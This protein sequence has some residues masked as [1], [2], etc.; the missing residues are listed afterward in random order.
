MPDKQGSVSLHNF[1]SG[2]IGCPVSASIA[3]AEAMEERLINGINN[4]NKNIQYEKGSNSLRNE[5]WPGVLTLSASA[6]RSMGGFLS[7]FPLNDLIQTSISLY[8]SGFL[9]QKGA[10]RPSSAIEKQSVLP[11]P[12]VGLPHVICTSE[13]MQCCVPQKSAKGWRK[14]APSFIRVN[15][16]SCEAIYVSKTDMFCATTSLYD[17][18]LSGS[19]GNCGMVIIETSEHLIFQNTL[20][21]PS[22]EMNNAL[23]ECKLNKRDKS[24]HGS[25][26]WEYSVQAVQTALNHK[27]EGEQ[28]STGVAQALAWVE[29]VG[30]DPNPTVNG[31]GELISQVAQRPGSDI[32][33]ITQ[34]PAIS[35]NAVANMLQNQQYQQYQHSYQSNYPNTYNSAHTPS[36][37]NGGLLPISQYGSSLRKLVVSYLPF[38]ISNDSYPILSSI[39]NIKNKQSETLKCL[40]S[41]PEK[42]QVWKSI[43][44]D[45]LTYSYKNPRCIP[46]TIL[47][48][49]CPMREVG[50]KVNDVD[51]GLLSFSFR[52]MRFID[53]AKFRIACQFKLINC[54]LATLSHYCN[55]KNLGFNKKQREENLRSSTMAQDNDKLL[56]STDKFNLVSTNYIPYIPPED[57][58]LTD[59]TNV[60]NKYI[61]VYFPQ[62]GEESNI[63]LVQYYNNQTK[64]NFAA[65]VINIEDIPQSTNVE[66]IF[67]DEDT[68]FQYLGKVEIVPNFN[69]NNE[70]NKTEGLSESTKNINEENYT[71]EEDFKK[72]LQNENY[73]DNDDD[74]PLLLDKY[75]PDIMG[76]YPE[77]EMKQV[78]IE[79]PYN[80]NVG[81][82]DDFYTFTS[83]L[84]KKR[85]S[86]TKNPNKE[87][88][89]SSQ[90]NYSSKYGRFGIFL[91][92][93]TIL[94]LFIVAG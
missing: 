33:L 5:E 14:K 48:N 68:N 21:M 36:P 80:S 25:G 60:E 52:P 2:T 76:N 18:S 88:S 74:I 65:K 92:L 31:L 12:G 87:K 51:S 41:W 73:D 72:V 34:I 55:T 40:T 46:I 58:N 10:L 44:E 11:P 85:W 63:T 49:G 39:L 1:Q 69:D 42:C 79:I 27:V 77:F 26:T 64:R 94:I 7:R 13:G 89:S 32:E 70:V 23:C 50:F 61:R 78:I 35:Q 56:N 54:S 29:A 43:C 16:P 45:N 75:Q 30:N 82:E 71:L 20:R 57:V 67:V 90:S 91:Y 86:F 62:A 17:N 8:N 22:K 93:I 84:Q 28:L 9:D 4:I 15:D 81:N 37:N 59:S 47:E 53:N 19:S 83:S 66:E 38:N 6:V 3:Y 24:I